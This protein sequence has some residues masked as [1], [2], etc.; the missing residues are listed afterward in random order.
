[1]CIILIFLKERALSDVEIPFLSNGP[2]TCQ[3]LSRRVGQSE[4]RQTR[5]RCKEWNPRGVTSYELVG[6]KGGI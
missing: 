6:E 2:G 1:M 4:M 5:F 3:A